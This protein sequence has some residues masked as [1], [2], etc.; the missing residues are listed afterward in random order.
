MAETRGT[1]LG[2]GTPM[3]DS[4]AMSAMWCLVLWLTV[5]QH[6]DHDHRVGLALEMAVE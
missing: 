2:D 1:E 5:G 6:T 3:A 4:V